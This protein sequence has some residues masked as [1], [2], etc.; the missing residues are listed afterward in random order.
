LVGA[1]ESPPSPRVLGDGGCHVLVQRRVIGVRE[2]TLGDGVVKMLRVEVAD[3]GPGFDPPPM[4]RRHALGE[5]SHRGLSLLNA[6]A[7]RWGFRRGP[8]GCAVWFELD[9]VPGRRAWM[10]REP[11]PRS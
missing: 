8:A 1:V 5:L 2:A 3:G 11:V 9:L 10:G 7:D 6:L 4:L